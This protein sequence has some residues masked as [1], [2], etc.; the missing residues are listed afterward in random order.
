M[1]LLWSAAIP[2]AFFLFFSF[3]STFLSYLSFLSFL[4]YVKRETRH[5]R[6]W[7]KEKKRKERE[8]RRQSPHS[9]DYFFASGMANVFRLAARVSA[10]FS[11]TGSNDV[12]LHVLSMSRPVSVLGA[13]QRSA[14][15]A[16]RRVV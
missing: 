4:R 8:K 6:D 1:G 9:K 3:F 10:K 12:R 13:A 2:A 14:N 5:D 11:G 15:L 16:E 7:Y